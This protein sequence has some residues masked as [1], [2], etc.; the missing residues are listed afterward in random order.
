MEKINGVSF[1]E[2][3]AASGNL[4]QGMP[5]EKLLQILGLEKPVWDE[6]MNAWGVRLGELMTED[7]NYATKFG[8][9]FA[10][11][12]AGRFAGQST[13]QTADDILALVPDF[14]TYQ[15]IFW[16]QSIAAGYGVD[17]AGVIEGYGLDLG[18]WGTIGMHYSAEQHK[19]LDHTQPDYAQRFQEFTDVQ[20]KWR[21]HFEAYYQDKKVDL[22]DD[23]NF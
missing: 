10:N 7:M 12:S 11:P 2:Y 17:P 19:L 13:A 18:K 3:A 15:K 23:I 1:E 16:H 21:N 9:L 4:A 22:G 5:E 6:T 20:D 8:E 14:D